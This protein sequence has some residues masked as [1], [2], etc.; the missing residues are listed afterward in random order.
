V[1]S[2]PYYT[3]ET[4]QE[5]IDNGGKVEKDPSL[6]D[7]DFVFPSENVAP[8]LFGFYETKEELDSLISALDAHGVR[9]EKLL[10]NIQDI[11]YKVSAAISRKE[12]EVLREAMGDGPIRRSSRTKSIENPTTSFLM[13][14]NKLASRA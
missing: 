12:Q 13:Y 9:E 10:G 7:E 3:K 1:E 11:Y 6:L 2:S 4:Q 5:M 14:T 8:L